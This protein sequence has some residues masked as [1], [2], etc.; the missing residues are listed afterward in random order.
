MA[1]VLE[2]NDGFHLNYTNL[3]ADC[4]GALGIREDEILKAPRLN[5]AMAAMRTLREKGQVRGHDEPVLFTRLPYQATESEHLQRIRQW[6]QR[7]RRNFRSV[8]S[9]GIGGSYLG[10]QVLLD[11][12]RSPFWNNL[13]PEEDTPR[14]FFAG[15]NV[16]PASIHDLDR[17][18]SLPETMFVV[19]SKSG[20]T[21]ET[22]AA[23]MHFYRRVQ[24]AG[25]EPAHHFTAVTDPEQ[26]ILLE[27][28]REQGFPVFFVP[29]GVGGRWSVLSDA[30]LMIGE[31][32]GLNTHELLQGA[33]QMDQV[34]QRENILENPGYLYA[35]LCHL[36]YRK[37]DINEVVLMPYCD[38]LKSLALWYVQLL[39]ESLGKERDRKGRRVHEGRTPIAALGTTDMHAQT[40]Q[41]REGR[42]NKLLT[43]IAIRDFGQKEIHLPAEGDLADRLSFV[44]G[45]SFSHILDAARRANED[46]LAADGRP[47]CCV[48]LPCLSEFT[49]GQLLYFFEIATAFEGELLNVNAFNQPGVE[50]YKKIM[51]KLLDGPRR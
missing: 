21:T 47:S 8:V 12:G 11:A 50:H 39:A 22:M 2:L 42:R 35:V 44:A 17:I 38:A 26:G 30:G 23:F 13:P 9:L 41:H 19:I 37:S 20:T 36:F 45:H 16:D 31:L 33:R 40:Q 18:L 7:V 43:T 1:H 51:K 3:M 25:L 34:C 49:L 4:I 46:A 27:I 6:G 10:N 24:E 28:A 29:P 15:N 48:S 14:I 5:R 32:A